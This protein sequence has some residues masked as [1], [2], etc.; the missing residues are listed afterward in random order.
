MFS[1]KLR[2]NIDDLKSKISIISTYGYTT[3]TSEKY[4]SRENE[5]LLRTLS[6]WIVKNY[7]KTQEPVQPDLENSR[8][9]I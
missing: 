7:P 9:G 2:C 6:A 5:N 8:T 3:T 4:E 1:I